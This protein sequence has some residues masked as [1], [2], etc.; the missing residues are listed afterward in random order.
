MPISSKCPSFGLSGRTRRFCFIRT[1]RVRRRSLCLFSYMYLSEH[2][3]SPSKTPCAESGIVASGPTS[4]HFV[5]PVG[6]QGTIVNSLGGKRT[7]SEPLTS[8]PYRPKASEVVQQG[9]ALSACLE[10][11]ASFCL[12][13][14]LATPF[15]HACLVVCLRPSSRRESCTFAAEHGGNQA[16]Y[17]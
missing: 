12:H 13:R 6:P 4:S 2:S 15:V 16:K 11:M 10:G 17:L 5:R 1:R 9:I 3:F 8:I 14:S 7:F